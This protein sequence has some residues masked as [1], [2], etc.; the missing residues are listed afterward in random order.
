MFL[1]DP[2]KPFFQTNDGDKSVIT[3]E[4]QIERLAELN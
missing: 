2:A 4:L 1:F 3:V